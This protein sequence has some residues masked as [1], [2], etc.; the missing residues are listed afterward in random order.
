MDS[1]F[2]RQVNELGFLSGRTMRPCPCP[3]RCRK[4]APSTH[5]VKFHPFRNDAEIRKCPECQRQAMFPT[6]E[7]FKEDL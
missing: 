2:V 3:Y 7:R 5:F 6:G 4:P 1:K